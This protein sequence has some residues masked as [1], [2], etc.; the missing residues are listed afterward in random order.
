MDSVTYGA[1]MMAAFVAAP[2]VIKSVKDV[3]SKLRK[4]RKKKKIIKERKRM[5]SDPE[6]QEQKLKK[7][8]FA[9]AV[10]LGN[11]ITMKSARTGRTLPVP[12]NYAEAN[13]ALG[14]QEVLLKGTLRCMCSDGIIR[15]ETIYLIQPILKTN[16]G[17]VVGPVI[18]NGTV[19]KN[20]PYIANY[21]GDQFFTYVPKI[22]A[23]SRMA[24]DFV[25]GDDYIQNKQVLGYLDIELEADANGRYIPVDLSNPQEKAEYDAY[26]AKRTQQ[27]A[28]NYYA[29]IYAEALHTVQSSKRSEPF[30]ISKVT[31]KTADQAV[32]AKEKPQEKKVE[33][34]FSY[35]NQFNPN[36]PA[37]FARPGTD[38]TRNFD[39]TDHIFGD[40]QPKRG[41]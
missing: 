21:D 6:Y 15:G 41:R 40:D 13:P 34:D 14:E 25:R 11:V 32:V 31:G 33:Y 36:Q 35:Y 7:Q 20:A 30:D 38:V 17:K 37:V 10:D 8:G 3:A 23:V 2:A 28:I 26:V 4:K 18:E 5:N 29:S 16:K 24:Y 27:D 19:D 1:L 39:I 12:L 9:K 22:E